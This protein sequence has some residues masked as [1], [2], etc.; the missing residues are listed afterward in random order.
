M[1]SDVFIDGARSLERIRK[2][3]ALWHVSQL[4][5]RIKSSLKFLYYFQNTD[6]EDETDVSTNDNEALHSA[7]AIVIIRGQKEDDF[8]YSKTASIQVCVYQIVL[9]LL[10]VFVFFT[11]L[12]IWI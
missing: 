10:L 1:P 7:D 11:D 8:T 5:Y 9:Y 2:L 4:I 12:A 6:H 3:Y